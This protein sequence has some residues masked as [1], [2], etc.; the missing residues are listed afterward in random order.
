MRIVFINDD[1]DSRIQ[2]KE[3]A[4]GRGHRV[5]AVES[6]WDA[7]DIVADYYVIDMSAV[8]EMMNPHSM[9]SP[10]CKLAELHPGAGIIIMSACSEST[11][12]DVIDD[13]VA[14]IKGL[15]VEYGGWGKFEDLAKALSVYEEDF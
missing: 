4:T 10:I 3:W 9:Y 14:H 8:G 1:A 11:V 15:R 6:V 12:R 2:L 7:K 5:T 13:V